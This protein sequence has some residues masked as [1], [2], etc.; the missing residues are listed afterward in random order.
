[1]RPSTPLVSTMS[2]TPISRPPWR[3]SIVGSRP[4]RSRPRTP[5]RARP[6]LPGVDGVRKPTRPKLTP[7]QGVPV[8]SPAQRAQRRAVASQHHDQ[9]AALVDELHAAGSASRLSGRERRRSAQ[10]VRDRTTR[11]PAEPAAMA[12]AISAFDIDLVLL[13]RP[14]RRA[15]GSRLPAGPG[16]EESHTP[17]TTEGKPPSE[18]NIM[19]HFPAHLGVAH[20]PPGHCERPASNC[21]FTSTTPPGWP[22]PRTPAAAPAAAR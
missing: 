7:R 6:P 4:P 21:G 14:A 19:H 16:T 17:R 1:M 10:A 12:A 22:A 11:R 13:G 15:G 8:S 5:A 20:H 2:L 9:I 3:P 18:R